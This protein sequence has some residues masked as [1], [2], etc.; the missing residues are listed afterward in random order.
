MKLRRTWV[1]LALILLPGTVKALTPRHREPLR[2]GCGPSLYQQQSE[3]IYPTPTAGPYTSQTIDLLIA[4]TPAAMQRLGSEQAITGEIKRM[5]VYANAAHENS[6]TGVHFSL[7]G[8]YALS[9][10][11]SGVFVTDVNSAALS[12]GVWDELLTLRETY[13]ADMVSVIVNGTQGGLYCGL[14]YTNGLSGSLDSSS[15]SMFSVVSVSP[16]CPTS[17]LAHELG[18]NLGS[19]HDQENAS[20]SGWK[21]YSYGYRFDGS[22][23]TTWHTVMA[24]PPDRELPFFSSPN[25]S[26]DGVSLGTAETEDNVTSLSLAAAT[27][28]GYYETLGGEDLSASAPAEVD[29][30]KLTSKKAKNNKVSVITTVKASGVA[31]AYQPIE[32]FW[33][34]GKNGQ[35]T[36]AAGGR[37]NSNGQI[38]L[39]V[40]A[41]LSP[42]VFYQ[43]CLLGSNPVYLCSAK[44]PVTK[45]AR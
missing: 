23:G 4:Y 20:T 45:V 1:L 33:S 32:I 31:A 30:V 22:S 26:Y 7:V 21:P 34:L 8:I 13:K 18:H 2:P 25:L 16:S 28:A 15:G 11:S 37:T 14:G 39:K 36:L 29:E 6:G 10:E 40:S 44:V 41:F 35:Q 3:T 9:T 12:D 17:T 5:V 42:R 19:V 38:K 43:A 27:V 24:V